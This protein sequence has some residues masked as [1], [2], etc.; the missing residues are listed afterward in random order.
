MSI[1]DKTR[2]EARSRAGCSNSHYHFRK[3][4]CCDAWCV[5]DEELQDL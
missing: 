2:F 1:V 3:T 4:T 5:E